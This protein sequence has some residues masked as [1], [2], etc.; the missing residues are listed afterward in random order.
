MEDINNY[1][2]YSYSLDALKMLVDLRWIRIFER[3]SLYDWKTE[4][5]HYEN[6]NIIE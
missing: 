5:K 4:I 2:F 6:C 1:E 3:D